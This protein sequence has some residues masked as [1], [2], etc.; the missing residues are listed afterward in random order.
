MRCVRATLTLVFVA[1][2]VGCASAH[3]RVVVTAA[4]RIGPLRIDHSGRADVIVFAGPP[5][6]ERSG[7][8]N[9]DAPFHALGY[10]CKGKRVTDRGGTPFCKTV[11]YLD[12]GSGKLEI[13]YTEDGRYADV[14]GVH[15]GMR[16]GTAERRL[17]RRVVVGCLD[18]IEFD[19]RSAFLEIGFYDPDPHRLADGHVG[20]LVVHSKRRNPGVLDCIDS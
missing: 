11:F 20:F 2:L 3:E 4:G 1:T 5:E 16:T 18:G 19:T 14:H 6:S 15:V 8:Y 10:G 13:L 7:A 17:H 12:R 9:I